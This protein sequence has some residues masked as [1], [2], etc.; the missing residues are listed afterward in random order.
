MGTVRGNYFLSTLDQIDMVYE[1]RAILVRCTNRIR[2]RKSRPIRALPRTHDQSC[3][4]D[5]EIDGMC[6]A[7]HIQGK[8]LDELILV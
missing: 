2:G 5:G 7:Y 6:T 1:D 8:N 3:R 4:R